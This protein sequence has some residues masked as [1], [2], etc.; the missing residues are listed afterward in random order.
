MVRTRRR[1]WPR[2]LVAVAVLLVGSGMLA[3]LL[4]TPIDARPDCPFPL[5]NPGITK[6]V[7]VCVSEERYNF[8]GAGGQRFFYGLLFIAYA[9]FA[10]A[11]LARLR[12]DF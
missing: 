12:R 10:R 11:A 1:I 3:G 9:E 7:V 8:A 4:G 6:R 5:Q 2:I